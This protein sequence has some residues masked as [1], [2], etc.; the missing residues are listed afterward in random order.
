MEIEEYY[1]NLDKSS[2]SY[3]QLT[4]SINILQETL[5]KYELNEIA[6]PFNGGKDAC[7]VFHLYRYILYKRKV[8]SDKINLIYFVNSREFDEIH[9]F[10]TLMRNRYNLNYNIHNTSFKDGMIKVVESGIKAVLMGLRR[11]DPYSDDAL[12]F[13]NSSV[14]WPNF[15]RVNA[16]L[17]ITYDVVWD[18]LLGAKLPY[19]KLYDEGYTSLGNIDDTI[20]NDALQSND[21]TYLP[22]YKLLDA[23]LERNCRK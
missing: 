13:H 14:G 7:V 19:C 20:K 8:P 11:G 9:E 23:T 15:T 18:F 12:I 5:D 2:K 16:I 21:G 10:M 22:A 4:I 3:E 17:H 1:N 6:L